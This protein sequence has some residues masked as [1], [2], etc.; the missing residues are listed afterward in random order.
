MTVFLL[1]GVLSVLHAET[2][3]LDELQ[4]AAD[5]GSIVFE[6]YSGPHNK[7]DTVDEIRG[8]G[9]F[10]GRDA[11]TV[12]MRSDYFG[13]YRILHIIDPAE[14]GK[15]DADVFILEP[16]ATVDHIKNLRRIIAGFL[17]AA[18]DYTPAQADLLS[19]FITV[20]NAV[21]RGDMT[22]FKSV[23]KNAVVRELKAEKTGI[24]LK[25][26]E[27]PGNTMMLIPLTP[28]AGTDVLSDL[29]TD[30]LSDK[31]VIKQMQTEPDMGID[32]RQELVDLKD[33]EVDQKRQAIEED[34]KQ[35]Q[36][37][38]AE[39]T[40]QKESLQQEAEQL[41]D[42]TTD[43]A[44]NR[45]QEI[46]DELQNITEEEK[47]LTDQKDNLDQQEKAVEQREAQIV[48]E[49]QQIAE[50][51]MTIIESEGKKDS[52]SVGTTAAVKTVP[53]LK[54]AGGAGIYTGQLLLIDTVNGDIVKQSE[55]DSIRLRGYSYNGKQILSVAGSSGAD[56]IVSLVRIDPATLEVTASG[57]AEVFTESAVIVSS[58]KIY[59]VVKD[60]DKWKI[61]IF[62][63]NLELQS[64]ST[65]EVFP[66]TDIVISGTDVLAQDNLGRII[67]ISADDFTAPAGL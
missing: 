13:K 2:V 45:K 60:S 10:L 37:R 63:S 19:E 48:E 30:I 24:A 11:G 32:K 41:K 18:Y 43:E 62:N 67:K 33:Q 38:E 25:Y 35:I 46:K 9:R 47:Q 6:N 58:G 54:L 4:K 7:I 14:T 57:T 22:Y 56:R 61:G 12:T 44:R 3:Y 42:Q 50:D 31:D 49:R 26:T 29:N 34:R 59:A 40:S 27:W 23:Y 52:T 64:V 16:S 66:V 17:E 20:Y 15:L 5:T 1:A 51:Q 55:T 21:H 53:F 28:Q 65:S 36:D 8:I 39:L